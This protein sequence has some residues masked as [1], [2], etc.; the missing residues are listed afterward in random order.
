MTTLLIAFG[1]FAAFLLAYHTYGRFLGRKIFGLNVDNVTPAHTL[2]DGSDFEPTRKSILFGHH[3]TSIAG[4]GPIVGPAIAVFWGWLPALL[5]VVFGSIFIGAVHDFGALVLSVRNKGMS[6]GA[7]AEKYLSRRSRVLLLL[8]LM[9]TLTIVLAIFGLVIA[10]VFAMYPSGV[11]AVW[12]SLPIAIG[13]GLW[14]KKTTGS[15]L[16]PSL[17]AVG[18]IYTIIYFGNRFTFDIQ[19][20][21]GLSGCSS[22]WASPV[23]LW[24][25]IL[26][27]YCF[28]ASVLPVWVLLQPRDYINSQQLFVALALLLGGIVAAAFTGQSDL[29]AAAPAIAKDVPADA[30]PILPFLF[31]TIAC[32]AVSGFHSLVSSGTS[33]KQLHCESHARAI[34][35][36]SMLAEGALA[37][38]VILACCAGVGMG[39]F[40]KIKATDGAITWVPKTVPDPAA[41]T[42]K[43]ALTGQAAWE[44]RYKLEVPQKD[45]TTKPG[46]GGMGLGAKVSAFVE[47]GANFI[48]ALG[49][50][51]DL[52]IPLELAIGILGVM[53]AC[54][55]ATTLDTATRLYRYVFQEFAETIHC[56]PL[57][58]KYAATSVAV[59]SGLSLALLAGDTP[60]KGGL[61][62]WPIF[63]A[64]NQILAG[65]CFLLI[66]SYVLRRN[67][68]VWFLAIPAVLM[69]VLPTWAMC[70]RLI[71]WAKAEKWLLVTIGGAVQIIAIILAIEAARVFRKLRR[72]KNTTA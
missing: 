49:I 21:F 32:G 42:G 33:S 65:L 50:P 14:A 22:P 57:K 16:L 68:P 43:I 31:I 63:G 53:V 3:Y 13:L 37:V 18:A 62:L 15:I 60:A 56:P 72:E 39:S 30:P 27:V 2:R 9:L 12:A 4:T 70:D 7:L 6:V 61:T 10:A 8:L 25:I 11:V 45:G 44:D 29:V 24:T 54:F 52:V 55:A 28:I 40:E 26:F 34:G 69:L 67:K 17:L 58:N 51:F 38:V 46:W 23:V 48:V 41:P 1:S 59:A 36:G 20:V 5:W 64:T 66:V 47:G 71:V 35:Y 19:S